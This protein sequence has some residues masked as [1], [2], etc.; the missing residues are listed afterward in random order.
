MIF[1]RVL[2]VGL[3]LWPVVARAQGAAR[4]SPESDLDVILDA[5]E[6]RGKDLKDFSADVTLTSVSERT[7]AET[8]QT[9]KV[10]YQERGP[11]DA[12][13]RVNFGQRKLENGATQPHKVD[14]LLDKGLLTD[15]DYTKKLE[16]KRQVIKPGQ[17]MNLLKLGEGPFPLP[18]GQPK[19]EVKMQFEV[20][21]V[22]PTADDPKGT[23]HVKLVP[24]AGSQFEKRFRSIDVYLDPATNMPARIDTSEK[25]D[26][27]RMTELKNLKMNGGVGDEQFSLPNI[28]GEAGWNRREEA[29]E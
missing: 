9:G 8:S 19:Q 4:I 29:F 13:I 10:A 17:K 26:T 1:I 6:A 20:A 22:A 24:K 23:V 14:Y 12:R 27:A 2:I 15:R 16:V 3:L 18:I 25:P 11:G 7:G 21:K 28:D 5:L